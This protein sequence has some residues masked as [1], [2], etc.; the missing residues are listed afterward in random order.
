MPSI[1]PARRLPRTLGT[2]VE[3]VVLGSLCFLVIANAWISWRVMRASV[4]ELRQKLLQL[5]LVWLVPV[6]GL[7]IVWLVL[8]SAEHEAV[9]E[10][11]TTDL[12]SRSDSAGGPPEHFNAH[13][14]AADV[15]GGHGGT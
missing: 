8:R 4:Y 7:V 10:R 3:R 11:L 2:N 12:A 1:L 15:G 9:T 6:L 14:D 13:A 5:A